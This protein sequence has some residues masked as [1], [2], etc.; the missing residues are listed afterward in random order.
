M[1]IRSFIAATVL[2][3]GVSFGAQAAEKDIVDTA[4]STGMHNTLVAAVKAA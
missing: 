3:A 4:A 1:N 2:V